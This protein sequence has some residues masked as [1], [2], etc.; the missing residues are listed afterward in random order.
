MSPMLQTAALTQGHSVDV[1]ESMVSSS[2]N[3]SL[4]MELNPYNVSI[5]VGAVSC[6]R[7]QAPRLY[8]NPAA[9]LLSH[10][11][12]KHAAVAQR[13][14]RRQRLMLWLAHAGCCAA[15]VQTDVQRSATLFT[16]HSWVCY[17]VYSEGSCSGDASAVQ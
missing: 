1:G 8:R 6:L 12:R 4:G 10:V 16:A 11:A 7:D 2:A 13:D 15:A 3:E 17:I 14:K 9:L 5:G